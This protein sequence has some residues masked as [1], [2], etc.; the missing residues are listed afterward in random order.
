MPYVPLSLGVP[1]DK[2]LSALSAVIYGAAYARTVMVCAAVFVLPLLSVAVVVSVM[3]PAA[4]SALVVKL[5]PVYV[6]PLAVVLM[7]LM[8]APYRAAG[9]YRAGCCALA[10]YILAPEQRVAGEA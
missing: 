4:V 1:L 8:V 10:L 6:L 9:R 2:H 3:L 7:L 5:A